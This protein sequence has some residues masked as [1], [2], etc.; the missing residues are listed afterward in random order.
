MG[1]GDG[2]GPEAPPPVLKQAEPRVA[3]RDVGP[4]ADE[5]AERSVQGPAVVRIID[6]DTIEVR[7]DG[8][9]LP[10]GV[11]SSVRLLA[12]DAPERGACFSRDATTRITE[13]LPPGSSLRIERD[14]RLKDPYDRYL[15]YAWNDQGVFVN[16]S[17]VRSGHAKGVLYPPNDA[18]WTEISK[19]NEAARQAGEGLWSACPTS[20]PATPDAP[21]PPDA[22]VPPGLPPGPPAGIPDVDCADLSGPVWVGPTD[23]HR[24]DRDGDGIGCDNS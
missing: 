9:I 22:D 24:L 19:A 13:L 1:D 11:A 12:I 5:Q 16:E 6:G 3:Q 4:A 10:D 7:G 2:R 14:T 20:T 17:L 23:P 15:L 18:Y 21:E 8:D